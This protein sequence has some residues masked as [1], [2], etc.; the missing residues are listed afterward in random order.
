MPIVIRL[1]WL[2]G[3]AAVFFGFAMVY[4]ALTATFRGEYKYTEEETNRSLTSIIF[5]LIVGLGL[6]GFAAWLFNWLS[7]WRG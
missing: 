4:Y 3:F 6:L 5:N 2:V 7:E 1:L